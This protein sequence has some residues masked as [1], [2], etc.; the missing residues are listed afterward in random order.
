MK[1]FWIMSVLLIFSFEVAAII[2]PDGLGAGDL[3]NR[4]GISVRQQVESLTEKLE[5][6]VSTA[7]N[8][9]ERYHAMKRTLAQIRSLR[10]NSLPQG[11]QDEAHMDLMASVFDSLPKEANFKRK[12]CAKYEYDLINQYEPT[13]EEMPQEPAVQPGWKVLASLCQ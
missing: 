10:D 11:A 2:S 7:K 5:K 8:N 12:D 4:G 6:E 13:T 1:T 9:K 3:A